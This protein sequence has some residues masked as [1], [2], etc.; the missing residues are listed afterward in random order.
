[1][2]NGL[3]GGFGSG[4]VRSNSNHDGVGCRTFTRLTA[5]NS[6]CGGLRRCNGDGLRCLT[7]TPS[8]RSAAA[9][10]ECSRAALTDGRVWSYCSSNVWLN[11]NGNSVNLVA[12]AALAAGYIV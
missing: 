8:A 1:M 5:G 6:I 4:Y 10:S 7:G 12:F 2:A 11:G 3:V 9:E